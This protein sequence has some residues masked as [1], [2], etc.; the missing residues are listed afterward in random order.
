M[1]EDPSDQLGTERARSVLKARVR[2]GS[3]VPPAELSRALTAFSQARTRLT[4]EVTKHEDRILLSRKRVASAPLD[5]EELRAS[6][7]SKIDR[8]RAD[9]DAG[10]VHKGNGQ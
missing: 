6:L 7:G 8:I 1:A 10:K 2:Q 9:L 5:F 4:E 3:G